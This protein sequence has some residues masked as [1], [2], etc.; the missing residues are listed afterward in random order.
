MK[1]KI[2]ENV[3]VLKYLIEKGGDVNAKGKFQNTPLHIASDKG[4]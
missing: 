3:D 1:N 4:I 2:S